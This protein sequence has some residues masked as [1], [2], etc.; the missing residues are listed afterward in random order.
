MVLNML[1]AMQSRTAPSTSKTLS[2]A[3]NK[4]WTWETYVQ[5][6]IEYEDPVFIDH[7]YKRSTMG[8]NI[9]FLPVVA[10]VFTV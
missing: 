8:E 10:N 2:K 6:I 4:I 7:M 1:F 3:I 9:N 5:T